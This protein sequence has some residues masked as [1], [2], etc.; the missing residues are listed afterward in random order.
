MDPI[1]NLFASFYEWFGLNPFYSKD[2]GDQLRGY[3]VTCDANFIGTHWYSII[4][5][6]MIGLVAFFYMLQYHFLDRFRFSRR[7][8]WWM[9]VL[10]LF[11]TTYLIAFSISYNSIRNS[12]DVC[13]LLKV[14]IADCIG[15]GFSN[16]TWSLLFYTLLTSFKYPK[17]VANNCRYT[18]FWKP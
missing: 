7:Y 8:H 5:F 1:T 2:M 12:E 3:D 13:S 11:I 9:F 17:L 15:F 18:T 10:V 14:N 16:A 4:G 6:S